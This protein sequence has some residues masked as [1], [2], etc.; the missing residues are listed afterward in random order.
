MADKQIG[1][2]IRSPGKAVALD[3]KGNQAPVP[4]Q[5]G[6]KVYENQIIKTD[7]QEGIDIIL[8]NGQ[9]VETGPDSKLP[10][11]E[12]NL[13]QT[14]GSDIEEI[15]Q[16]IAAGADPSQ[17]TDPPA[18]GPLEDDGFSTV[19][20]EYADPRG[21]VENGFPTIGPSRT[22]EEPEG[23]VPGLP[24]GPLALFEVQSTI[25]VTDSTVP[26]G[27]PP[28]APPSSTSIT[29]SILAT[30]TE[31]TE[32]SP[33]G[34]TFTISRSGGPLEPG[35]SASVQIIPFADD[36]DNVR[37]A[38]NLDLQQPLINSIIAAAQVTPDI[39]F[40]PNTGILTF[41][42]PADSLDINVIAAAD[43]IQEPREDIVVQLSNPSLDGVTGG[44]VAIEGSDTANID[45]VEPPP[46]N[47]VFSLTASQPTV[48]EGETVTFTVTRSGGPLQPGVSASVQLTAPFDDMDGNP[49]AGLF[50][51][52]PIFTPLNNL[53]VAAADTTPG[54]TFDP[55][56]G[57]LTFTGDAETLAVNVTTIV[58]DIEDAGEDIVFNISNPSVDGDP[59]ATAIIQ[60]PPTAN[61]DI[62]EP[63]TLNTV[64][65]PV[66]TLSAPLVSSNST[67]SASDDRILNGTDGNDNLIAGSGNDFLDGGAG[68]DILQAGAGNDILVY[69]AADTMIDGGVGDD[70]LRIDSSADLQANSAI[71]NIEN[72]L[73]TEDA[74]SDPSTG[75]TV[76]LRAEDVLNF[77][78]ADNLLTI[79]GNAGDEV[80]LDSGFSANNSPA[81]NGLVGYTATINNNQL[82]VMVEE[83]IDVTI[84]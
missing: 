39:T 72:I 27:P 51:I 73:I 9:I 53:I 70:T 84:A 41:T 11:N 3:P 83:S 62:N 71:S 60:G 26:P 14:P 48:I 16:A 24:Q 55:N 47:I 49:A 17:V 29:F 81:T 42:G 18:A 6:D 78:D 22:L 10:L 4:L 61:V 2:V 40:D 21:L 67:S 77:T 64:N 1:T 13:A 5:P 68:A 57:I 30:P 37:S 7:G 58:D 33:N 36:G 12:E 79:R 46:L 38:G 56:T 19:R 34:G 23:E 8:D 35:V 28:P 43:D 25:L 69:D 66:S 31:I 74:N 76:Q 54:V 75:S 52:A 59:N 20:I 44:S 50:D 32:G 82:N 63:V 15:Q 80:I 65:S 45:I